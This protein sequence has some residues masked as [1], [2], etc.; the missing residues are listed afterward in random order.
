MP[1]TMMAAPTSVTTRPNPA[2]KAASTAKR[3]SLSTAQAACRGVAP[4][5]RAVGPTRLSRVVT[6]AMT[7]A[8]IRGKAST[9]WAATM[10]AGV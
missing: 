1:P 8:V 10:A 4:R 7:R 2:A 3:A 9:A 5:V 6:A